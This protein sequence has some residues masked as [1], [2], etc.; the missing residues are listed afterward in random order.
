VANLI[1]AESF[2]FSYPGAGQAAVRDVTFA[3]APGEIFG[4]LG[5]SGAGKSTTLAGYFLAGLTPLPLRLLAPI[6]L[7]SG[8]WAPLLALVLAIAA[9]NKVAGFAVMKVLNAINLLP[10]AA[11]FIPLPFQ[12]VVGILPAYWPMRARWSA[13][14]GDAIG[15]YVV[16]GAVV[17]LLAIGA[18]AVLFERRLL[19]RG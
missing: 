14:A 19:R 2:R 10:V 6:A 18:V 5:P 4:F 3:V 8:L 15:P 1:E 7:V 16:I 17:G 9:P 13:A 12:Y 11:F